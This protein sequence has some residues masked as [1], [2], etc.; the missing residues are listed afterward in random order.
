MKQRLGF[1]SNSSSSS[2]IILGKKL[3]LNEI[4]KSDIKKVKFGSEEVCCM[5]V[6]ISLN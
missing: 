5:K 3:N 1:V 2:F 6:L 4:M